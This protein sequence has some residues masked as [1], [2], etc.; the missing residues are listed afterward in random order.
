M[1]VCAE[2]LIASASDVFVY[3]FIPEG[4]PEESRA[5]LP[6]SDQIMYIELP[7][8]EDRMKEFYHTSDVYRRLISFNGEL[9]DI[10][11]FITNRTTLV[12]YIRWYIL[13]PSKRELEWSKR[14]IIIED[15]PIM[16][17]KTTVMQI[18]PKYADTTALMGYLTADRTLI[19]AFW[20]K[21]II[22]KTAKLYFTPANVKHIENTMV[23]CTSM[24]HPTP[25]LKS[26]DD[27]RKMLDGERKFTVS[28][29]GRLVNRDFITEA[30]DIML[31]TWITG[32]DN[33]R[34]VLC[35][36]S[37]N[38]GRVKH[39][40]EKILE[41][42][43]PNR[44]EFWRIMREESDVGVFM[45]RDEDYSMVMMETLINGTPL[46]LYRAPH[47]VA[48]VG[49]EY[50]FFVTSTVEAMAMLK[51]F[52]NDYAR[53]Y[54][55]FADWSR[56][57]L[58]ALLLERDKYHVRDY[59]LL[60]L[61]SLRKDIQDKVSKTDINEIVL[62]IDQ[63]VGNEPFKIVDVIGDLEK[64][65]KLRFNLKWKEET[66]FEDLR[67]SFSTHFNKYRI[68]LLRLGY[69]DY[70]PEPGSMI[71]PATPIKKVRRKK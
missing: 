37:I 51:T 11:V 28:Y 19:S 31:H 68:G 18:S 3:W 58:T 2:H 15:M 54:K 55:K 44:E 9:W 46:I 63:V 36:V 21:D 30:F 52:R 4:L 64:D 14:I 29:A 32:G 23:E 41:V 48:S 60:E 34:L 42:L 25:H 66:Q 59:A 39:E 1:K 20:E 16:S 13:R 33:T 8:F 61:Q 7:Y 24:P 65:K 26:R 57:H 69:V 12:P 6:V 43:K 70:S 27:I 22:V 49:K 38:F 71:K 67:L 50:P 56:L 53:M 62:L 45:S 5:W 35:T 17:F 47:S 40:I 10:D